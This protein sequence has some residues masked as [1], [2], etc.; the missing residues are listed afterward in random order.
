MKKFLF[1]LF[2]VLLLLPLK[3]YAEQ[4]VAPWLTIGGDYQARLD[5]LQGSTPTFWSA[6]QAVQAMGGNPSAAATAGQDYRNNTLLTNR[7]GLN[8]V[9]KPLESIS[10]KARL[11]MYKV[12]GS[13]S[14]N[15][16]DQNMFFMDRAGTFDGVLGHVPGSDNVLVDYA[17]ATWSNIADQPVWFSV[18][19]RPSTGGVPGNLRRN[20]VNV[21]TAGVPNLLIDYAFDGFSLGW[22]PY[23]PALPGAYAKFCGGRGFDSGFSNL[24]D[25]NFVGVFVVPYNTDQLEVQLQWDRG[26]DVFDAPPDFQVPT[27]DT[28]GVQEFLNPTTNVG[29]ID[30]YGAVAQGKIKNI[31]Y[32]AAG[33]LSDAHPNGQRAGAFAPFVK[34]AMGLV[35][36]NTGFPLQDSALTPAQ[37]QAVKNFEPQMLDGHSHTGWALYLGAR[38]DIDSTRTKL[39]AEYNHGS[40]NWIGFV[41]AGDDMWTSKLGTRGDVYELYAIQELHNKVI[42][43]VG[44]AYF[45]L[46]WQYYDFKNTGSNNWLGAS[47]AM[48]DLNNPMNAQFFNPIKNAQ[49]IYLTFNVNF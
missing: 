45:R 12:W 4:Q 47:V 42:D 13:E 40:R 35:D 41:P 23:I 3:G 48:N 10:V 33:A 24:H 7:F 19:R 32:F 1:A 49:D 15:P 36:P 27:T 29:N 5:Y 37:L 6:Q 21:G 16:V 39:G 28:N 38:Y 2:A 17:Y 14:S 18:G 20:A 43:K 8:F 34:Q 44:L 26:I 9:A 11:V 31:N 22:A 30:W 46:G 25:T